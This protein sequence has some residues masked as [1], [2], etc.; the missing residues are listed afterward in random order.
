MH[1]NVS[2][3]EIMPRYCIS[4]T[5]CSETLL[6][7]CW[8]QAT[9]LVP[10]LSLALV[11]RFCGQGQGLGAGFRSHQQYS[12]DPGVG[13]MP[14][15]FATNIHPVTKSVSDGAWIRATSLV[16]LLSLALVRRF[17]GPPPHPVCL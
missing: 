16:P 8:I 17:C 9:S 3:L 10:L 1:T 11:R 14:A 7:V 5:E 12:S 13:T 6:A 15:D 4:V 2:P